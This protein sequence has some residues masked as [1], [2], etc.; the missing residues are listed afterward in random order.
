MNTGPQRPHLVESPDP[1]NPA[2][3]R[4]DQSFVESAGVKKLL[5]TVPVRRPNPQDFVRVHPEAEFSLLAAIIEFRDERET[6]LLTPVIARE[7]PGEY[8]VVRLHTT[9][10]RQNVVQLWPVKVPAADGRINEW[11]R[12]AAEAAELARKKWVRIKANMALGAYEMFEA[13]S[14]IPD[15][16]WPTQTLQELLEIAFR[17]RLVDSV[18]HPIIKRLR[19]L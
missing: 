11:H 15:P 14:S 2:A 7:L 1:F 3:L 13:G 8:S 4:L 5:N 19:G 9:I 17:D 16:T 10:S 6:Y 12:S 18:T